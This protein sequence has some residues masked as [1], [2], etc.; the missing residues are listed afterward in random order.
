MSGLEAAVWIGIEEIARQLGPKVL[1]WLMKEK[2]KGPEH[3]LRKAAEKG[4]L[5][6][7]IELVRAGADVNAKSSSGKTA[8]MRAAEEGNSGIVR[9]LLENGALEE[10]NT[11]GGESGKSALMRASEK[12]HLDIVKQLLQYAEVNINSKSNRRHRTALG[13][14]LRERHNDVADFLRSKGAE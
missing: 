12:G 7:V 6:I 3:V 9:F 10:V 5:K 13:Y 4:Y 14:A 11:K 8:L 2:Q 1:E